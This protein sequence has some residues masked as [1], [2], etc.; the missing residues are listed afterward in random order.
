MCA[1]FDDVFGPQS[2]M[3]ARGPVVT[4]EMNTSFIRPIQAR[5]KLIIVRV[6][7]LSKSRTLF[8]LEAK[9]IRSSP[10]RL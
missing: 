10:D 5:R 7:V 3:A 8:L 2:Y 4:N 6:E 1:A 9:A